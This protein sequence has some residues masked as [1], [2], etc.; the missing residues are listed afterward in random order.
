MATIRSLKENNERPMRSQAKHED[1][2]AILLQSLLEIQK[3]LQQGP[4]NEELKQSKRLK[5]PLDAHK[6]RLAHKDVGRISSKKRHHDSKKGRSGGSVSIESSSR[7]TTLTKLSSSGT[8]SSVPKK[9]KRNNSHSSLTEEFK[10][11][12]HGCLV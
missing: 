12:R 5:T 7:K 4:R 2:N 8:E 10:K 3:Y 11:S 9:R 1:L 6:H